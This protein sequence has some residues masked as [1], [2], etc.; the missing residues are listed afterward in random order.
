MILQSMSFKKVFF[1]WSESTFWATIKAESFKAFHHPRMKTFHFGNLLGTIF[2]SPRL[3]W[4][5]RCR[6]TGRP[7]DSEHSHRRWN[8]LAFQWNPMEIQRIRWKSM[9][10]DGNPWNPIKTMEIA[11]KCMESRG[12]PWNPV[13]I[14]GIRWK[15]MEPERN[16]WN[17]VKIH[18]NP[19][20][21]WTLYNRYRSMKVVRKLQNI[22]MSTAKLT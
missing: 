16:P 9:E 18:G 17:P 12:N 21:S 7:S 19:E 5:A 3:M 22:L 1:F 6:G 11:W 15:S 4:L 10:S 14:D 2:G 20:E 13:E 8:P